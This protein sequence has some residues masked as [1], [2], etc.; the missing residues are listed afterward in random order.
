MT[1]ICAPRFQQQSPS[2]PAFWLQQGS[3][4]AR[5]TGASPAK[6][7]GD[8]DHPPGG[9]IIHTVPEESRSRWSHI[10][11]LDSFFKNVYTYHQKSGFKV[12]LVQVRDALVIE[13]RIK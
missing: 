1:N 3:A 13:Y 12:M 6:E 10:D 8:Q 2:R 5:Q 7:H 11:D 9:V 4:L